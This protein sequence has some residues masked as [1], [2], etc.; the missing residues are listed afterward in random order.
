MFAFV[1]ARCGRQP[2]V[3]ARRPKGDPAIQPPARCRMTQRIRGSRPGFGRISDVTRAWACH[4]AESSG[5]PRVSRKGGSRGP[6]G[7]MAS[8]PK[9]WFALG[10][11][12]Q[13]LHRDIPARARAAE[14]E[15]RRPTPTRSQ[16]ALAT[17]AIWHL[18]RVLTPAPRASTAAVTPPRHMPPVCPSLRVIVLRLTL[19]TTVFGAAPV[20]C[21]WRGSLRT[22]AGFDNL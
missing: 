3:S 18:R 8:A 22:M 21:F 20:S 2:A 5:R 6:S 10:Q 4:Q 17:P 14:G 7:H 12:G 16:S 15:Q 19:T 9:G 1:P 13:V 11:E